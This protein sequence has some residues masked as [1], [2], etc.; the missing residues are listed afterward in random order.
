LLV[1]ALVL[2]LVLAAAV[3]EQVDTAQ[4]LEHLVAVRPLKVH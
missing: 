1:V 2:R 3:V 4:V